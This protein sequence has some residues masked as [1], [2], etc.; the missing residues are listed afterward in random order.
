VKQGKGGWRGQ[1]RKWLEQNPIPIT[2][3]SI[4]RSP[5]GTSTIEIETVFCIVFHSFGRFTELKKTNVD[6]RLSTFVYQTAWC[7]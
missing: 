2:D 3:T 1:L 6:K 4:L 5:N 7:L